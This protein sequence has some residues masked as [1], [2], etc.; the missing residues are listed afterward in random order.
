MPAQSLLSGIYFP[1]DGW[2]GK[3]LDLKGKTCNGFGVKS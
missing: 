2:V 1:A 3:N